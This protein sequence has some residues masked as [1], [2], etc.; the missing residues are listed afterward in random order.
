MTN[1]NY[2][3][4]LH[5]K[6]TNGEPFYVGKGT[7]NR[8]NSKAM[9]NK[10][11]KNIVNKYDFDVILLEENLTQEKAFELEQYWIKKI[12]RENL[13][14]LTDGG[15]GYKGGIAWNKGIPMSDETKKKLSLANKGKK[16]A[17]KNKKYDYDEIYKML[18]SGLTQIEISN[19]LNCNQSTISRYITRN[20]IIY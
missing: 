17:S 9:R 7:G 18:K 19:K 2:Y 1:D 8:K 15:D 10:W 5:I 11:W 12:G 3:I 16:Q 13:C 20:N 6:L 4:Y 14:N